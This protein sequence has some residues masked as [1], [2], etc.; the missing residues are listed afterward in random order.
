MYSN[1]VRRRKSEESVQ[2]GAWLLVHAFK[3]HEC[4]Y[5]STALMKNALD[6]V[7]ILGVNPAV[8]QV[9]ECLAC[10]HAVYVALTNQLVK[11]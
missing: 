9:L 2:S 10:H 1:A 6:K 7:E 3:A 8:V 11:C 4:I 5:S